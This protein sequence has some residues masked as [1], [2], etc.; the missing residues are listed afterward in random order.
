M[1]KKGLKG[2]VSKDFV[3][4]GWCMKICKEMKMAKAEVTT[5]AMHTILHGKKGGF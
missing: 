2:T 1:T 5:P 3:A 4:K